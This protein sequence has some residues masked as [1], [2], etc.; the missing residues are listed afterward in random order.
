GSTVQETRRSVPSVYL[1]SASTSPQTLRGLVTVGAAA[2]EVDGDFWGFVLGFDADDFTDAGA[3][4]LLVDWKQTP[5]SV[6]GV[7]ANDG[8]ALSRVSG[9]PANNLEFWGHT[10]AV[11]ELARG[12]TLGNVGWVTGQ[13][14]DVIIDYTPTRVIVVVDGVQQLDVLAPVGNPFSAGRLGFYAY[15]QNFVTFTDFTDDSPIAH[16]NVPI[17]FTKTFTDPGTLDTFTATINWGDGSPTEA[18]LVAYAAGFGTVSGTH[19]YPFAA[20]GDRAVTVTIKDDDDATVAT[21]TFVINVQDPPPPPENFSVSG[22]A[23]SNVR[24]AQWNSSV[25]AV[26]YELKVDNRTTGVADV[27]R[28]GG[29]VGTSFTL[30]TPL[31]DGDYRAMVRGY[32]DH[33]DAG[34]WSLPYDF[35]VSATT[36][37]PVTTPVTTRFYRAYNPNADFHFFTTSA[38]EFQAVVAAGYHDESTGRSGFHVDVSQE[39]GTSPIYRLYNIQKG[40]H[41][42]TFNTAERDFLMNLVPAP[43][44]GQPATVETRHSEAAVP[45]VSPPAST[46]TPRTRRR[47]TPCW[48]RTPASGCSMPVLDMRSRWGRVR[49]Q[50]PA[51]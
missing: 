25:G 34:G 42:Y 18:G 10:T 48:P 17:S 45:A 19:T 32:S 27:L 49:N 39:T 29:L 44:T 36:P 38:G 28:V 7:L 20:L 31:S 3:D 2:G 8:L 22:L 37:A 35:T 12:A 30:V 4:Y 41:Y 5:Q 43:A 40:Y 51:P 33:G 11:T 9:A 24:T 16:D 50:P 46:C 1:S 13:T 23:T 15:S 26:Y 6:S 21:D 47:R 14:Y